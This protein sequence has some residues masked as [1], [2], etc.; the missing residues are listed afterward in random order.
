MTES[1][2]SITDLNVAI[3]PAQGEPF[4]VLQDVSLSI[5]RGTTLGIVGESGSG[6][7]MLLRAIMDLLPP[8]ATRTWSEIQFDGVDVTDA[9]GRERLPI[10]MVFQDPLTSFDPLRRIG[11]HLTEV[12]TRFQG[13]WGREARAR[14]AVALAQVGLPDPERVLR[15]YPHE[16]S[17]G[18]RQRVMIAMT[19]LSEP[20]LIVAD[21]PTTAL[22]ATIQAQILALFAALQ[23]ERGLTIMVVTHDLGVVAALCD[24]VIVMQAGRVVESGTVARVFEDPQD[25]YTRELL[26]ALPEWQERGG[27]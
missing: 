14:A 27:A 4:G 1:I 13:V 7:T 16:L 3:T 22:D 19:L 10:S 24:R 21:E 8:R 9:F 11:A 18:M 12:V 17:G 20:E 6:K 26:A 5:A 25:P 15:Q 2:L 23:R